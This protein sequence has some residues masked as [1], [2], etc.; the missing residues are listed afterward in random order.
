VYGEYD[1]SLGPKIALTTLHTLSLCVSAWL[2]LGN[3]LAVLVRWT[4]RGFVP[5]HPINRALVFAC[6]AVYF[7]RICFTSFYLIKRKFGWGEAV[8]VG[9]YAVCV[10]GFFA[11]LGSMNLKPLGWL[12]YVAAFVYF[13]GSYLNTGSEF[14]RKRWKEDSRHRGQLYTEGLFRY[15]RHI[16]YFG[17]ELLFIG[18]ALLTG[19]LWA[20]IVPALMVFG[21]TFVNIPMLD[22][23]LE[24]KYGA[25]FEA[26]ALRTKKFVPYVY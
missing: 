17:D 3:G 25:E 12:T 9:L 6:G 14:L 7:A 2:L 8:G 5:G 10:H 26:Y 13:L 19:S 18:Y 21:F 15:S 24:K 16:N 20:L 4:G 23:Y 11:F 22:A 1:K